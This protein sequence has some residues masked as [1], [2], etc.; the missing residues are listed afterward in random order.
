MAEAFDGAENVSD[1]YGYYIDQF[2]WRE[3]GGAVLPRWLEGA[4]LHRHLHRPRP[5]TNSMIQRYGEDGPSAAMQTL[6]QKTQPYV[7]VLGDGS[8]AQ[9]RLRLLQMNSSST[10]AGSMIFGIYENQI[11]KE[12]GIWRIHGMDLDYVA[13]ADYAGGWTADRSRRQQPLRAGA[14]AARPVRPRR[15]LARRDLAP[16]PRIRPLGFHFANPSA[17]ANRPRA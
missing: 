2:S 8:R 15:P 9:I 5:G 10:N 13:L 16:Y 14:R 17:A 4:Q 3:T 6:H 11:V 7:T 12:D 1:A